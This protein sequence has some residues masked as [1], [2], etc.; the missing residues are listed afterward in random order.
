[1][2]NLRWGQ[3]LEKMYAGRQAESLDLTPQ[4]FEL[5]PVVARC[6]EVK[7]GISRG[8]NGEG[9]HQTG[10]CLAGNVEANACQVASRQWS[11]GATVR[12]LRAEHRVVD[13][14][15]DHSHTL[16]WQ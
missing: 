10:V 8:K 4:G 3:R 1:M 9:F 2:R 7:V 13:T 12:G 15:E 14:I 5:R 6:D 11:T 16:A